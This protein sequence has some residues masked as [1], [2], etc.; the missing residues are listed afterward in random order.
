M[1]ASV[2]DRPVEGLECRGAPGWPHSG[3]ECRRLSR[4]PWWNRLRA[5]GQQVSATSTLCNEIDD[6]DPSMLVNGAL[7]Q[8]QGCFVGWLVL[9][10]NL[11]KQSN[12]A[13][14][15]LQKSELPRCRQNRYYIIYTRRI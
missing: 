5:A 3:D 15:F 6:A 14:A 2:V 12:L 11:D 9:R 7:I 13:L 4:R 1:Y 10:N 8:L